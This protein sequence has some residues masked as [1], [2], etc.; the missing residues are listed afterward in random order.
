MT[1]GD[2]PYGSVSASSFH[3]FQV[4]DANDLITNEQSQS[5][6]AVIHLSSSFVSVGTMGI[7]ANFAGG[8]VNIT[9]YPASA[10]GDQVTSTQTVTVDPTIRC[11]TGASI[12]DG[13]SGGPVWIETVGGP[14]VVGLVSSA[15][16]D[17]IGLLRPDHDRR[18]QSD[19]GVGR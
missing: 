13:S 8:T 11:S 7:E 9:G 18:A 2:S 14:E 3:Y 1:I 12:G 16:S 5:D 17:G 10:G 15:A 6:Y 19:R 4:D